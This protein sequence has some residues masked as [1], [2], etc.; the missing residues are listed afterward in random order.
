MNWGAISVG[1]DVIGLAILVSTLAYLVIEI[2]QNTHSVNTACLETITTGFNDIDA[3]IV[4][5]PELAH[6]VNIAMSDPESLNETE[7][8]RLAFIF[9]MFYNQ[10]YKIFL[11]F[12]TSVIT[13]EEW[14]IYAKQAGWF[15]GS[16]GGKKRLKQNMD[17]PE[18]VTAIEP[19]INAPGEL[20]FS[21]TERD[22]SKVPSEKQQFSI[23]TPPP[24]KSLEMDA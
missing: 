10:Y 17:F 21:F 22:T 11:L 3:A 13:E 14:A 7:Q 19:Y 23:T 4:S 18:L 16:L 8:A 24:N 2:R 5:D 12:R 20:N 9:R 6:L 1:V 15:F